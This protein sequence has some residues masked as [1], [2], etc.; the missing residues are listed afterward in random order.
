MNVRNKVSIIGAG[1]VGSTSAYAIMQEGSASEI[2]LIDINKEKATG[3][4]LDLAQGA[5]FVKNVEVYAGEMKDLANSSVVV[6]AAGVGQKPGETRLDILKKN[7]VIFKSIV[8]N[9]LKYAPKAIILVVSNPV[10]ILTYLT[11][12]LSGLPKNQVIGSGTV[13][14]TA[15]FKH[16]L[17]KHFTVDPSNVHGYVIGEHGDS[18]IVT[19]SLSKIGAMDVNSYCHNVCKECSKDFKEDYKTQISEQV[20]NSA[21]EI[22]ANKGYTN[23]AVGL[24]V[25]KIVQAILRDENKILT[26][27]TLL[28]GEYGIEDICISVPCRV[29]NTGIDLIYEIDLSSKELNDLV[30]S[31]NS[32]KDA[33]TGV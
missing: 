2:V 29:N 26:V 7:E 25:S 20:K 22:I 23:Y 11:L 9:I 28:D 12:K 8:E 13:L 31:A 19:W 15:R 16:S 4:A 14:D 3:E 30:K 6:I 10:D 32:L 27:S 5:A 21:Y 24:A 17:S 33:L 18:E 1:F